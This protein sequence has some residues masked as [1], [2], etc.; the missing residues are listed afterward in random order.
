MA[1]SSRLSVCLAIAMR[2]SSKIHCARSISRQR[3]TP[4][5]AGIGQLSIMRAM[6]WR[7]TSLSL[8]GC[9]RRLSVQQTVRAA[10]VEV[11]HPISDDLKPDT[12]N[13]RRLSARRAII[14]CG[15]RQKPTGLRAVFRLLRQTTQLGRTKI[16]A[17]WYRSRHDEPP[18]FAMLNQTRAHPGIARESKF[19]GPGITHHGGLVPAEN[20]C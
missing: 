12:A 15:E 13:H 1:R 14:N 11:Q 9:P 5:T 7:W 18:W 6:A 17:Q 2:N 8:D 16:S 19:Q 10:L 3:T 4:W 20:R